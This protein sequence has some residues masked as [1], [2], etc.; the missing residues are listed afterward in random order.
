MSDQSADGATPYV[1]LLL[2][3]MLF[4]TAFTSSKVVVAELPHQVA[5]AL[6]FGGAAVA[7]IL[8]LLIRS[9]GSWTFVRREV[10][11]AGGAGLVGVFAYNLFFFWAIAHA[12]A[13]DGSLIVP[14]LSPVLTTVAMLVAGRDKA[15]SRRI[16][17]LTIGVVGAAVFFLGIGG[18]GEVSGAR[19]AGDFVY[20]GAAACWAAYS[21]MSKK[22][23]AGMDPLRAT[24]YATT[25]GALALAI[26]AIPSVQSTH[27]DAVSS[28]TWANVSFLAIGPTAI[29]YLFYFRGLRAVSPVTA[30]I[31]MFTVPV[32]GSIS[33]IVFLHESF[34]PLQLT[35]AVITTAGALL[36]VVVAPTRRGKAG[37]RGRTPILSTR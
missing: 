34:T 12:P 31:T 35:G 17:G 26:T 14:V 4:G 15:T 33:S 24:T 10:V 8:F 5:A 11:V 18:G 1:Y 20:L 13:I 3:M 16:A 2:T 21:I 27:W 22:I 9:R 25:A 6:R 19:L 37:P 28:T 7:L 32:F 30:T 29:A 23:L 36:A